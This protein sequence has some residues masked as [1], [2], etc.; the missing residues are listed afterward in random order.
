MGKTAEHRVME[1]QGLPVIRPAAQA[2]CLQLWLSFSS[3]ESL[4]LVSLFSYGE[5]AKISFLKTENT[6]SVRNVRYPLYN[7]QP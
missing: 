2:A 4:L 5:E 3:P 1:T 7:C 6:G